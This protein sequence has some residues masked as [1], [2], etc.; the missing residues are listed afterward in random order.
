MVWKFYLRGDVAEEILLDVCCAMKVLRLV[1]NPTC[2]NLAAVHFQHFLSA[3]RAICCIRASTM[4]KKCLRFMIDSEAGVTGLRSCTSLEIRNLETK[5]ISR[6]RWTFF[7]LKSVRSKSWRGWT[8]GLLFHNCKVWRNGELHSDSS[9]I[10]A[11]L[12]LLSTM[13]LDQSQYHQAWC[14]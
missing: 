6:A 3:R 10:G 1:W 11:S 12:R 2:C 4:C 7:R 13:E 14:L 9:P 5:S 8:V